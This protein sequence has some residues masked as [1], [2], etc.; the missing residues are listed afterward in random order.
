[1]SELEGYRGPTEGLALGLRKGQ[2][3]TL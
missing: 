3:Q 1:M 2:V